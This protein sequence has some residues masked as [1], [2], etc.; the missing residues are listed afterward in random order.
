MGVILFLLGACL[1]G[2]VGFMTAAFC[3]VMPKDKEEQ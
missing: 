3:S 1:G 2:V